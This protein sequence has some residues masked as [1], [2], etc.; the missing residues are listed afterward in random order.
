MEPSTVYAQNTKLRLFGSLATDL[1]PGDY[2]L[3]TL[4]PQVKVR[5][6]ET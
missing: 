2:F 3:V 1:G 6:N 5:A 4:P